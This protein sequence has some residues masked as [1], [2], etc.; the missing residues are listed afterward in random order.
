MKKTGLADSPFFSTPQQQREEVALPPKGK[1]SVRKKKSKAA[2]RRN[3]ATPPS[4]PKN[5]DTTIP[6]N[7]DT[8]TP[9]NHGAT[10]SRYHDTIIELVRKA[11]KELGKEAATHRFTQEEKSALADIISAYKSQGLKTSE[12]EITRVAINF[13]ISDYKAIGE[14]S[15]LARVLKA[16][17]K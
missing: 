17:N 14:N 12:N 1:S 13:I 3:T 11:V 6:R 8:T 7:H 10:V 15:V 5:H 2:A 4:Q 16:L 9:R